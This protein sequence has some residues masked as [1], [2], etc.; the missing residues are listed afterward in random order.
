MIVA[1]NGAI[2][3]SSS[4]AYLRITCQAGVAGGK[5]EVLIGMS[6]STSK[7]PKG[8]IAVPTIANLEIR[9]S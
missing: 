7:N 2:T 1:A 6:R 4:A 9:L 3:A 5:V 8:R